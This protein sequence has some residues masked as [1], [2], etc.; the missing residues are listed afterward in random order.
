LVQKSINRGVPKEKEINDNNSVI[1]EVIKESE[2][3]SK[4][5]GVRDKA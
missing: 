4:E 3:L 2:S 1:R 5:E